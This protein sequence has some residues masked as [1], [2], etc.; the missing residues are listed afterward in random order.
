MQEGGG[1]F[2]AR[3]NRSADYTWFILAGTT[4]TTTTTTA[5]TIIMTLFQAMA[6]A[7]AP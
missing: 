2:K 4:T 1:I 6:A 7:S 3:A 5:T